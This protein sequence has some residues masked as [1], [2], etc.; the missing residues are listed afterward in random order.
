MLSLQEKN[1]FARLILGTSHES[2]IVWDENIWSTCVCWF[3]VCVC[4]LAHMFIVNVMWHVTGDPHIILHLYTD[5][6]FLFHV[7]L[8]A[9]LM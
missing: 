9:T 6:Y 3:V 5:F 2:G 8:Q 1:S 7:G 4:V